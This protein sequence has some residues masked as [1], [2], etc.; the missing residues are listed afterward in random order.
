MDTDPTGDVSYTLFIER[1]QTMFKRIATVLAAFAVASPAMAAP[2]GLDPAHVTLWN[3]L[4]EAGL[5]A[6]VNPAPVCGPSSGRDVNGLYTVSTTHGPLMAICQ[7][8]APETGE[9]VTWTP[10]DLDTLRHESI[11]FIQ[12][13][14]DGSADMEL[15]PLFDGPGGL[16]PL[17][18]GYREV[19]AELGMRRAFQIDQVYRQNGADAETIRLEHEAFLLAGTVSA[20]DIATVVTAACTVK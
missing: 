18:S 6:Y 7:D 11:H 20:D 14:L 5:S 15:N 12:D 4:E 17:D 10:N 8:N 2:K 3:A 16:S 19:I 1:D 13:C 9:E